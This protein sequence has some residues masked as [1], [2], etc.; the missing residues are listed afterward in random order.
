M[1]CFC[2]CSCVILSE[3]DT[4]IQRFWIQLLL[5][6]FPNMQE[7]LLEVNQQKHSICCVNVAVGITAAYKYTFNNNKSKL[8]LA[9]LL[10]SL[11]KF[12]PILKQC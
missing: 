7:L 1:E 11:E 12:T 4:L 2:K 8:P 3:F 9:Q 10:G 5:T 6:P